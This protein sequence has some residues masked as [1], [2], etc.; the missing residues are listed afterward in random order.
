MKKYEIILG[1]VILIIVM[2]SFIVPYI[3]DYF[4]RSLEKKYLREYLKNQKDMPPKPKK[5][6]DDTDIY[7]FEDDERAFATMRLKE[8]EKKDNYLFNT[9]LLKI[10]KEELKKAKEEYNKLIEEETKQEEVKKVEEKKPKKEEIKEEPKKVKK[11]E[12]QKEDPKEVIEEVETKL[13]SMTLLDNPSKLEKQNELIKTYCTK[14][15]KIL[16][17]NNIEG[18]INSSNIGPSYSTIKITLANQKQI[19]KLKNNINKEIKEQY[20]IEKDNNHILIK[21]NNRY[22]ENIKLKELL[23]FKNNDGELLIPLGKNMDGLVINNN[24]ISSSHI[25]LTG[26][27][28]TGKSVFL[29]SLITSILMKY[30]PNELKL[31]LMDPKLVEFNIYNNIPHLLSPVIN[32]SEDGLKTLEKLLVEINKRH[33][34]LSETEY[35]NKIENNKVNKEKMP[36]II[37]IIDEYPSLTSKNPTGYSSLINKIIDKG[38]NVG[39][40]LIIESEDL[41]NNDLI[42]NMPSKIAFFTPSKEESIEAIGTDE[43]TTLSSNGE[44]LFLKRGYKTPNRIQCAHITDKE[45]EKVTDFLK[46]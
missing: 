41:N 6:K 22:K 9:G 17:D 12:I 38:S 23:K 16:K 31:V 10:K 39:V 33:N 15:R 2:L 46:K 1:F 18:K 40:Y 19:N 21:I 43:A 13:P 25:L 14:I 37:T 5:R 35:D 26:T 11:E 42:N 7:D 24:I 3:K 32:T 30:S 45:I 8:L 28:T 20:S 34:Q 36:Y 4:A 27:T 44:L 29:N